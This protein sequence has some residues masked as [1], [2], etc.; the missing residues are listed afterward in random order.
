MSRNEKSIWN[1]FAF[2]YDFVIKKDR[3]AYFK[4]VHQISQLLNSEDKV[5]E[6]ATGTGIIAL[7]LSGSVNNMEAVDFSPDMISKAKIKAKKLGIHNINFS[8]QDATC[9]TYESETFDYVIVSNA[10]HIMPEPE[11]ALEEIKRV[12][13]REGKLIAP[14]F[15]HKYNKKAELL[16]K[17]MEITG[18]HAYHKWTLEDYQR[19]LEYNGFTIEY[20]QIF[21]ASFPIA[22]LVVKKNKSNE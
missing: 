2:I 8:V 16:S 15:I 7:E 19:F 10:L 11:K 22:Y 5:L 21:M 13:T 4:I 12:L 1:R 18:F 14:T 6:I 17:L 20:S 9:L 3:D